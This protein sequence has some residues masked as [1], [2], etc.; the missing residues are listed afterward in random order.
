[1]SAVEVGQKAIV[2]LLLLLFGFK[3]G[4]EG[5]VFVDD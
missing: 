1:L 5:L 4:T 3:I 2:K